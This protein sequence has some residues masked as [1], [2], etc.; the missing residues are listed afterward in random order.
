MGTGYNP[1]IE[2]IASSDSQFFYETSAMKNNL[3]D[4]MKD[5][6]VYMLQ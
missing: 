4:V 6:G 1:V 3:C 2:Q 5:G